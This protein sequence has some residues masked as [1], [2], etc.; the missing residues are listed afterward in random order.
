[1]TLHGHK[2]HSK[3]KDANIHILELIKYERI[4]VSHKLREE[5]LILGRQLVAALEGVPGPRFCFCAG[6][7]ASWKF[8][9]LILP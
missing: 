3:C 7:A 8:L 1:M 5:G 9:V 6:V 2:V 4:P